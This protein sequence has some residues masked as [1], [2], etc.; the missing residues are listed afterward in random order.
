MATAMEIARESACSSSSSSSSKES[1][2]EDEI[3][4]QSSLI[5]PYSNDRL[6][7]AAMN[8]RKPQQMTRMAFHLRH[9]PNDLT[10]KCQLAHGKSR[11]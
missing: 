4:V 1:S 5:E 9:L 2:S 11:Y 6:L 7:V 10:K 8:S 3:F